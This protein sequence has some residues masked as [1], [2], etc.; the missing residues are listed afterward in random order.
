MKV[1]NS[2]ILSLQQ[3]EKR[4]EYEHVY[5]IRPKKYPEAMER[6]IGG[7]ELMDAFFSCMRDGGTYDDCVEAVNKVLPQFIGTPTQEVYRHILAF[8]AYCFQQ[9]FKVLEVERNQMHPLFAEVLRNGAYE[10]LDFAYTP[11]LLLEWTKGPKR[12]FKFMLDFKFTGQY[13]TDKEVGVY[14][15]LPK[16]V[17][18]WNKNNPDK[19]PVRHAAIAM[20]NTR[21][22]AGATGQNLFLLKWVNL[23]KEKLVNVERENETMA[24]KA[25]EK[26]IVG[27]SFPPGDPMRVQEFSRNV[28]TYGCKMCIFGEDLCPMELEGRDITKTMERNYIHNTYFDDNY[29]D[30]DA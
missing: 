15:Q 30:K 14:Q 24:I 16:Y 28:N 3:C 6:G 23:R 27:E 13:W 25:A 5:R 7:H 19:K 26:R 18:Y 29:G 2:M 11:D 21:A 4:F 17:I 9:E 22:S 12:G 10:D 1:S 8:G 20:M